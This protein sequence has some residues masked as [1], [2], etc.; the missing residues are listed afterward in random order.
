MPTL[1]SR[2]LSR[3][4]PSITLVYR[5]GDL[6]NAPPPL[7]P[8]LEVRR[9]SVTYAG[10]AER[11]V[12]VDDLSLAVRPGEIVGILGES[13]CGKSTLANAILR[14]LPR[15]SRCESGEILFGDR[16]L[17]QM[18]DRELQKLRGR[19]I[20]AVPQDP[21][22]ALN[23]VIN[24]GSQ[25]GEVLRAHAKQSSRERRFRV[26]DLLGEVGFENRDAIY[27]AFPH[28]LSGGQRQRVAIA[29]A[30]ACRPRLVIA[31]EPTSKL[32]PPLQLEIVHLLKKMRQTH[33]TAILLIT[34]DPAMLAGCANRIAVMYAGRIIE[35]G[36]AQAV[37]G[38]P[39]HPYT[40]ALVRIAKSAGAKSQGGRFSIPGEPPDPR[41]F[42]PGCRFEPRCTERMEICLRDYPPPFV[43]AVSRDVNCFLYGG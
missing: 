6:L 32:D 33:G 15:A 20:A 27:E 31:D 29:Q 39:L 42:P 40:Q 26:L 14:R 35:T 8:L 5:T 34:H 38:R 13:G 22:L 25:I 16:D 36:N 41:K 43:P 3:S 17:L 10:G 12:A 37:L 1:Q 30:L 24:A 2:Q 9:L 7:S 21:A 19:E 23:P 28:Q 11:I 18:R 4:F